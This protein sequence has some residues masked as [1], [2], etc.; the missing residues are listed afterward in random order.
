MVRQFQLQAANGA[1][2]IPV[3]GGDLGFREILLIFDS[4]PSAGTVT[5][6]Q[7]AIGSTVWAVI[8]R[9]NT[10]DITSGE[11]ALYADGAIAAIRVTFAGLVG[12]TNP[13]MWVSTQATTMP[14]LG[15]AT[16]GGTGPNARFRVDP[17]QTGFYARRMWR[18]S[19]EFTGLDATPIILRVTMPVNFIIHLQSLSVD[20]GGVSL[21]AYR[22]GQGTPGGSF[23]TPVTM[24]SVNFMDEMPIYAFQGSVDTGGT[25]TPNAPAVET[26][27]VRTSG[28]TA[29]Q[30]TVSAS[31]TGE[32][33]LAADAYY[34]EIAKLAGVS[35]SSS[36]TYSLIIEERPNGSQLP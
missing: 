8:N 17:G 35:G 19:F 23:A 30:T 3:S 28:A 10:A 26:L 7:R 9:G 5:V 15:M 12:G 32:R 31:Q 36:G 2:V 22:T 1:Q 21:R 11:L 24:Y 16:D 13:S 18:L 14:P 33:G 27:R 6:E 25:F 20:V 34:L 29:Q 4:A